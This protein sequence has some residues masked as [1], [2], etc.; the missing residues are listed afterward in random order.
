MRQNPVLAA[1]HLRERLLLHARDLGAR[2]AIVRYYGGWIL[3]KGALS[4]DAQD[5]V[6]W[7]IRVPKHDN[8]TGVR[9][10]AEIARSL[11]AAGS[12]QLIG[13]FRPA[14]RSAPRHHHCTANCNL[15]C[16]PR[17]YQ[18]MV[19]MM[20]G[21]DLLTFAVRDSA[22]V[23]VASEDEDLFPAMLATAAG[24]MRAAS[25]TWIRPGRPRGASPNDCYLGR[26]KVSILEAL[27]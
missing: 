14:N 10:R 17:A 9:F 5:L 11:A 20:L 8:K 25:V 7:T 3:P 13:T 21:L 12:A 22:H 24:G 16:T 1:E 18:K 15:H 4:Y 6:R 19:D 26:E 23:V 2:E 27:P